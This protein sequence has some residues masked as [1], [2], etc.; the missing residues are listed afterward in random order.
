M[1][2]A[3]VIVQFGL[4]LGLEC[5][6]SC[7][8]RGLV[9]FR[10]VCRSW[11][12]VLFRERTYQV[13]TACTWIKQSLKGQANYM[14]DSMYEELIGVRV[15]IV[16]CW[17]VSRHHIVMGNCASRWISK[18]CSKRLNCCEYGL[19]SVRCGCS[20]S[21]LEGLCLGRWDVVTARVMVVVVHA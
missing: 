17:Y 11:G 5:L 2:D 15:D 1:W 9:C 16:Y 7:N 20:T 14:F 8:V 12:I 18:M 13:C 6:T 4:L 19:P 21:R 3:V 10:A